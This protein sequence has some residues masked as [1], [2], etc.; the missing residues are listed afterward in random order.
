[1]LYKNTHLLQQN[2]VVLNEE[3]A[4]K[5]NAKCINRQLCMLVLHK[6]QVL[7]D[8]KQIP[9]SLR[10]ITWIMFKF[11]LKKATDIKKLPFCDLA[12]LTGPQNS[13]LTHNNTL[14][15]S[16]HDGAF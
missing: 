12:R 2:Q 11:T 15:C 10:M 1:M 6:V 5:H 9:E 3:K 8:H 13:T 14:E 16:C 4:E 7:V